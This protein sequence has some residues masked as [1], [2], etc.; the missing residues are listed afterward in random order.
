AALRDEASHHLLAECFARNDDTL[1]LG[2]PEMEEMSLAA[3]RWPMQCQ[4]SG[5]PIRPPVYPAKCCGIAVRDQEIGAAQSNAARQIEREL[6]HYSGT[7]TGRVTRTGDGPNLFTRLP[8]NARGCG[9][10]AAD[11]STP[12]RPWSWQP[13]SPAL[14]RPGR[15]RRRGPVEP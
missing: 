2:T 13:Q 4:G 9:P 3:T 1:R 5:W 15:L 6:H 8:P 12:K 11:R 10:T 7:R 14:H